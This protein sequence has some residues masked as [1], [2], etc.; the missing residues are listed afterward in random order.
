M[1]RKK[2]IANIVTAH[3]FVGERST[4]QISGWIRVGIEHYIRQEGSL[5]GF[6]PVEPY[7]D[8]D[9]PLSEGLAAIY[10]EVDADGRSKLRNALALALDYLPVTVNTAPLIKEILYS[11]R[12]LP[13][14]EIFRCLPEKIRG[15][16]EPIGGSFEAASREVGGR[17]LFEVAFQI[18]V[19]MPVAGLVVLNE[20]IASRN[21]DDSLSRLVA[22]GHLLADRT[23]RQYGCFEHPHASVFA[24]PGLARRRHLPFARHVRQRRIR[25]IRP[26]QLR[27]PARRGDLPGAVRAE[28]RALQARGRGS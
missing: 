26:L 1:A 20:L 24:H 3:Q 17:T 5:A 28:S 11:A 6:T 14:P 2:A 22:W 7:F 10:T 16:R 8:S 19:D 27:G 25:G 18:A 9:L 21:F 15:M 23:E 13:A 12:R 4:E